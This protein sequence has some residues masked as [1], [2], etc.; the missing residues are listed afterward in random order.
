MTLSQS[1][2]SRVLNVLA[3]LCGGAAVVL[4]ARAALV[5]VGALP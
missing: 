5:A 1:R 3:G 4:I 2:Q